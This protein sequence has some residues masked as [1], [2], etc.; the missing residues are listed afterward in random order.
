M[1]RSLA[2]FRMGLRLIIGSKSGYTAITLQPSACCLEFETVSSVVTMNVIILPF[3][4]II[5]Q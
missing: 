4:F 5:Q 3:P 1:S 2:S